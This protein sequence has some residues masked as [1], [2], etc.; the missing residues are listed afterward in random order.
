MSFE[1]LPEAVHTLY[2]ELLDQC[3]RAD[4]ETAALALPAGSFVSKSIKGGV[5]WYLQTVEGGQKRQRYLGPESPALR[6]WI[7]EAGEARERHAADA[8]RRAQLVAMLASGGAL[9]ES[10]A[11]SRVLETL[12]AAGVFRL[13][14]VLVGTHAFA[15]YANLLGVRFAQASLRTQ[16]VDIAHDPAITV[17]LTPE[18]ETADV[19]TALKQADPAFFAVP[20]LDPRSPS[21]SFKVRGRDLRVDFLTPARG[22]AGSEAVP[23]P[24]FGVA[25]TPLPFL[26]YLVE[27]PIQAAVVGGRGVLVNVPDPARFAVHKL[28]TAEQRPASEQAKRAKDLRQAGALFDVLLE[29][30]P[31]DLHRAWA[32]LDRRQRVRRKILA[33]MS[34]LDPEV[35]SRLGAEL[36]G[37]GGPV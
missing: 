36:P 18:P 24:A 26:D 27:E 3:V 5:Y 13:G 6:A 8:A 21:T 37:L 17:A 22:R 23:L 29:D 25:A 32:P 11:V 33:A 4:A 30:R 31:G 28:W 16:D 35:Q 7:D 19:S 15:V 10:A 1:R 2:A 34:H 14:G 20:G 12:A 9:R